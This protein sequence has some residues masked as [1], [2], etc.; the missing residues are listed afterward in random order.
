LVKRGWGRVQDIVVDVAEVRLME[1]ADGTVIKIMGSRMCS[2]QNHG[3]SGW[4]ARR[5]GERMESV[6]VLGLG[7]NG[8]V[9]ADDGLRAE[10]REQFQGLH[11]VEQPLGALVVLMA[12]ILSFV[13]R[14]KKSEFLIGG[15]VGIFI[16]W[17]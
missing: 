4:L 16:F 5:A 14:L 7:V 15:D 6:A 10:E 1:L 9:D 2:N 8:K 13:W 17:I 12:A 3:G 11:D